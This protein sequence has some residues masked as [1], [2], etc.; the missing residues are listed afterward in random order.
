MTIKSSKLYVV[1]LMVLIFSAYSCTDG[2]QD[3]NTD[4]HASPDLDPG[5]Q[6]ST[7]MLDLSGNREELWRYDLG[8]ASPK[9]QHLGGSWWTQHGGQYRIV[10]R[11]HWFS[12]W[13]VQYPREIKNII[14]VVER[15]RGV[16]EYHN[17]HQAARILK[18]Y[19]FSR[20]TDMYGDIPYS[21]AG[22]GFYDQVFQPKYD[23]QEDIYADF[24]NELDEAVSLLD[25]SKEEIRG[26]LFYFGDVEKWKRFGNS[27]RMRL[28]FRIIKVDPDESR[29][30]V[31]AAYNGGVMT[32]NQD[33]AM[34]QHS[35][36]SYGGG[37]N[38]GNGRSQV[39]RASDNSEGYRLVSTLVDYMHATSDPRLTRYGGTYLGVTG[40]SYGQDLTPYVQMGLTP[41]AMWWNQWAD[42]G[43]VYDDDNNY[44]AWLPHTFKHMMPSRYVAANNAPFFHF[45]Y[46]E[47]ELYLAEAVARGWIG[48]SAETH[49]R[50]AVTAS[51]EHVGLYPNAPTIT[52]DEMDAF[53]A[54][55]PFPAA[56]QDQIK[57]INEQHWVNFFLNG[58]EAYSN[59][60]RSGYP[61]L[62]HFESVEWYV[63]GAPE[64]PRRLLYPDV[65]AMLNPQAYQEAI[66]RMGGSNDWLARVW[67]DVP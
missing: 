37:E 20:L 56:A 54:A 6:I 7:V 38:R 46:A 19:I 49:F 24:F 22:R 30:Q 50:N 11:S 45:T 33:I 64:M 62:Q 27:L 23:R 13:E 34:M 8:I 2:F 61:K 5:V 21:E 66:D 15:T 52:S 63:A 51:F 42:Y 55:T 40:G 53:F 31:L 26:D 36:F 43:D 16:E 47:T 4:P 18:V 39:F 17:T 10:E 3:L 44:V 12:M 60:R 57:L 65:E 9:V 67:W 59:Y 25:P 58:V 1:S 41:G 29:A 32:S 35:N 14:D 28:G 48:G